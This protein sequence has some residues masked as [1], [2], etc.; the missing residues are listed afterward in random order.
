MASVCQTVFCFPIWMRTI[1]LSYLIEGRPNQFPTSSW[2]GFRILNSSNCPSGHLEL[3]Q[4][5]PCYEI[6]GSGPADGGGSY[7]ASRNGESPQHLCTCRT[8]R[9]VPQC[10]NTRSCRCIAL[11]RRYNS[12]TKMALSPITPASARTLV[13]RPPARNQ[14]FNYR[15]PSHA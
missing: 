15:I 8:P 12:D 9:E 10:C 11:C 5:S 6:K 3:I 7:P 14:K 2:L 13:G 4:M 1:K